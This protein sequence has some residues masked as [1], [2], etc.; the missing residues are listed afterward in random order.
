[1]GRLWYDI[2][3]SDLPD[4]KRGDTMQSNLG[5]R[6]E[7]TWLILRSRRMRTARRRFQLWIERWWQIE[8]AMRMRLFA[9]AE[10]NGGQHHFPMHRFPARKKKTFEQHM[11]RDI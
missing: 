7:R 11:Q 10:R 1:M 8:P 2:T 6:R 3:G 4:P 9:S 5:D